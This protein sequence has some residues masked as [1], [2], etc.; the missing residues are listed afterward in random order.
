MTTPSFGQA[1]FLIITALDKEA[2]AVVG[3]LENHTT[4]RFQT[5]DIRTYRCGTISIQG[6]NR[7]YRV[8]VV[9]LPNMGEL[10][11]ANATTDALVCKE[12]KDNDLG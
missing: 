7:A 5:R 1:D 9:L 8:V 2:K 6:S 12:H 3:R 4:E 11:A 10:A